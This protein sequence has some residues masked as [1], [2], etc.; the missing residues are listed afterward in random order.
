MAP[1]EIRGDSQTLW[2]HSRAKKEFEGLPWADWDRSRRELGSL[3]QPIPHAVY[4]GQLAWNK[5]KAEWETSSRRH[6]WALSAGTLEWRNKER[7]AT[8]CCG[9][10]QKMGKVWIREAAQSFDLQYSIVFS[11]WVGAKASIVGK[12]ALCQSSAYSIEKHMLWEE[13]ST[14]AAGCPRRHWLE[15]DLGEGGCKYTRVWRGGAR[16]LGPPSLFWP[17]D[18]TRGRGGVGWSTRGAKGWDLLRSS[19][20][21]REVSD[22]T[23]PIAFLSASKRNFN[24]MLP[25]E[26]SRTDNDSHSLWKQGNTEGDKI[27]RGLARCIRALIP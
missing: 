8:L 11:I 4:V 9:R 15:W 7:S 2:F 20:N 5:T 16:P 17:T 21:N 22:L 25:Y 13:R 19:A 3:R 10:I 24:R 26:Y 1:A 12:I 18:K 6:I 23:C 27:K 14:P